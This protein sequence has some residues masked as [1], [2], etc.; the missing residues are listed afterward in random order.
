M[1]WK[2]IEPNQNTNLYNGAVIAM[3]TLLGACCAFAVGSCNSKIFDRL[4]FWIVVI[5]SAV[6]GIFIIC[7]ALTYEIFVAYILYILVGILY[8]LLITLAR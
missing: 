2:T 3:S 7:I 8:H 6:Q 1:I 5:V 4:N